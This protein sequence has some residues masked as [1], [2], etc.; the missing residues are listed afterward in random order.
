MDVG[1]FAGIT[2]TGQGAA[3][4]VG[5]VSCVLLA[6][7]AGLLITV[8]WWLYEFKNSYRK[9][10]MLGEELTRQ[11]MGARDAL[12]GLQRSARDT[13]PE[14]AKHVA[15]AHKLMQDLRFLLSRGEEIAS[16]LE[17]MQERKVVVQPEPVVSR[18]AVNIPAAE[19]GRVVQENVV[20]MASMAPGVQAAT[21]VR[22]PLEE[23]LAGLGS[24]PPEVPVRKEP[25]PLPLLSLPTVKTADV[26]GVPS[27]AEVK[28]RRTLAE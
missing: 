27:Q 14:L 2:L 21:P 6:L 11:L 26:V 22:D 9:M 23:L 5:I 17:Q 28:L 7:V 12:M 10:P 4:Y 16:K 15:E 18:T 24:T 3:L 25:A 13:G 1:S 8:G 20:A 19:S